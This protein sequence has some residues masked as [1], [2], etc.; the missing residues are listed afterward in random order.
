[1]RTFFPAD[2]NRWDELKSEEIEPLILNWYAGFTNDANLHAFGDISFL[3]DH[4]SFRFMP[5]CELQTNTWL[6][7][8]SRD[9]IPT[10]NE[11]HFEL[12]EDVHCAGSDRDCDDYS[13]NG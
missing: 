11:S 4:Q 1:M 6:R 8:M 2:V 13:C 5:C 7:S 3:P 9:D 10:A 12:S